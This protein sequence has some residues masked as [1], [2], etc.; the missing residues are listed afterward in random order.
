MAARGSRAGTATS[1]SWR[2]RFPASWCA[3]RSCK[4]KRDYA[5]A[6]AVEVLEPSPDRVPERC[7]HEGRRCPGSPWQALRYERQVEHKQG[8]VDDALRRLGGLDGFELEPIVPA[9]ATLALPQQDGVLVRSDGRG[10]AGSCSASTPAAAG[11]RSWTPATACSPPS[12]TTRSRNLVR[13]WC[14][15]RGPERLRPPRRHGASCATS[16]YARDAA[17]ATCSCAW[18]PAEGEFAHE[19]LAE[20]VRA[21]VPEASTCCGPAPTRSPRCHAGR[22]RRRSLAGSSGCTRSCADLRFRISPEAFFQTNTEMAERLYG[23]APEYAGL[24]G[25]RARVRP[26]LRHRHAQPRAGAARRRGLGRRHRASEAIADAIENARLNEIDNVALLRRR[27]PRRAAAAGR[28]GAAAGRRRRR[29][30][31]RRPVARRS[32]GGCWRRSP[33]R[34]VYVSCNPTTLAP[35]AR[36]MVDAG[37]RLVKVRPVDMFPHTPHIECVALLERERWLTG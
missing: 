30:A 17:P 1:C 26:L 21:R 23:L 18:S 28:A 33:R 8:L 36:Q 16:S 37:Y 5:N 31:P 29:P 11:S 13:D 20:A 4:S 12:A 32:C 19:A 15:Q 10:R 25:T 7:D 35:N 24:S 2:A 9:V 22:R 34:I 27:R 14:A 3:P 6:R